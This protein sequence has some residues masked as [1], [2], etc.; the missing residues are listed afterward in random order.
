M[1]HEFTVVETAASMYPAEFDVGATQ[2][3]FLGGWGVMLIVTETFVDEAVWAPMTIADARNLVAALNAAI[4]K[5]EAKS[6]ETAP[7]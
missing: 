4:A 5:A 1:G 6:A 3:E 7:S 2:I